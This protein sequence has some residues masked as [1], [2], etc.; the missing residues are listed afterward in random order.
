[1]KIYTRRG[2]RGET[3]L[4]GG[5]G[6]H[7][8]ASAQVAA[9]GAVD[10]VNAAI[11]WALSVAATEE[12]SAERFSDLIGRLELIQHDLFVIGSHVAIPN[13]PFRGKAPPVP[14]LPM[15]RVASMEGWIDEIDDELPPLARFILPGGTPLAA[16]LHAARVSC[17]AAERA[18]VRACQDRKR[19]SGRGSNEP[20]D[21]G[22]RG[23]EA[24]RG[25]RTLSDPFR[26][27]DDRRRSDGEAGRRLR[28]M[29][30]PEACSE[31]HLSRPVESSIVEVESPIAEEGAER[32]A[33]VIR[34]LNRLSDL[35]FAM[36]RLANRRSG[37]EDVAWRQPPGE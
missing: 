28:A 6:R 22:D 7:S 1:M 9:L 17:R 14:P 32:D 37:R 21:S 23:G 30:D 11:G 12:K 8:K 27:P 20:T 10:A 18:V 5:R 31:G 33:E 3:H 29:S 26:A 16:A 35:L 4:L 2:D 15:K 25:P 24:G 19:R 36:G 13:R 34:Y